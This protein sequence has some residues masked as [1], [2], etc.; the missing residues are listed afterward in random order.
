MALKER[1]VSEKKREVIAVGVM[2][3]FLD[4]ISFKS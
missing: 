2:L 4:R 3:S 1:E